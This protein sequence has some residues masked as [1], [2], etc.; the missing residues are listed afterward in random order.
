MNVEETLVKLDWSVHHVMEQINRNGQ[1]I[2]VVVD[3]EDRLLAIVTDGDIRRAILNGIDLEKPIQVLIEQRPPAR[4][5]GPVT[6]PE[7]TGFAKLLEMMTDLS[8]RQIPIVN[9]LGKVVD[10]ITH[11]QLLR[12]YELPVTAVV[13]AGGLGTRLRPLTEDIPKPMLPIGDRPLL[14]LIIEQLR[15]AGIRRVNVSTNYK[16]DVITQHFGDGHKF[17][18]E[19][20]YVTETQPLG[21]AGALSLIGELQEPLL[22]VN[23][24]ILTRIN[25]RAMLYFH[26]E[27]QAQMTVAVKQH[28]FQIPYGLVETDGVV[29]SSISEKPVVRHFINAGIYLLNPEV[30]RYVPTGQSYDMPDLIRRV[31]AEKQRVVAFPI[32]EYWLDIGEMPDLER[33][34][35]DMVHESP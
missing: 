32:A 9:S 11:S 8:I 4:P 31:I 22:I 28:E 24:D 26:R 17:G 1:G 21:T 3:G 35:Q 14:E 27:N 10:V 25:F 20:Q 34:Q 2:A 15:G 19:I 23:G 7:G 12:E 29:V 30:C 13:M 6:A 18:V 5:Q 33:A 16:K